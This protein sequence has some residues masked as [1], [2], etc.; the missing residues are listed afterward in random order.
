MFTVQNISTIY[1]YNPLHATNEAVAVAT[2]ISNKAIHASP[3]VPKS[4]AVTLSTANSAD[5]E[6]S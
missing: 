4:T 1:P 6:Q 2:V 3:G 5:L